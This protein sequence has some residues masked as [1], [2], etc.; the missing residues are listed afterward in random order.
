MKEVD[1]NV[2][3]T[4]AVID[5]N[6]KQKEAVRKHRAMWRWVSSML[7]SGLWRNLLPRDMYFRDMSDVVINLKHCYL[8]MTSAGHVRAACYA[9]DFTYSNFYSCWCGEFCP[10]DWSQNVGYKSDCYRSYYGV[11]SSI[12]VLTDKNCKFAGEIA[13]TISELPERPDIQK[14][15]VEK[16]GEYPRFR[17]SYA[18]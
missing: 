4:D 5:V 2:Y 7:K 9:C 16:V 3:T 15:F 1:K 13:K 11:F 18:K 10:L 17:L 12:M 14:E 8:H 6:R